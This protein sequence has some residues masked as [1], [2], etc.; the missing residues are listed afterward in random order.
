MNAG[1]VPCDSFR[2]V[3]SSLIAKKIYNENSLRCAL[4]FVQKMMKFNCIIKIIINLHKAENMFPSPLNRRFSQFSL[5]ISTQFATFARKFLPSQVGLFELKQ[6]FRNTFCLIM[7]IMVTFC[8]IF[9]HLYYITGILVK[10]MC[11]L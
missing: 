3:S 7:M 2:Y 9:P 8:F 6:E 1:S 4:T 10:F 5:K 11:I